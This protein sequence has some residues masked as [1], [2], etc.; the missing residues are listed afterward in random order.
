[1]RSSVVFVC[2]YMCVVLTKLCLRVCFGCFWVDFISARCLL[3][4]WVDGLVVLGLLMVCLPFVR[5]VFC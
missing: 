3:P 1:M 4:C 2:E 5:Q